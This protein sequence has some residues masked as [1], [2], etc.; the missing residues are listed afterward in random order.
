MNAPVRSMV[1]AENFHTEEV[2]AGV[3]MRRLYPGGKMGPN[4]EVANDIPGGQT[5]SEIVMLGINDLRAGLEV[6]SI[7][8]STETF[9]RRLRSPRFGRMFLNRNE[10]VSLS[11][12]KL[13][14]Q[15]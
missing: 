9:V 13:R 1:P 14:S 15:K 6:A 5:W 12:L 4:N 7:A 3:T 8:A 2:A 11:Y 10:L